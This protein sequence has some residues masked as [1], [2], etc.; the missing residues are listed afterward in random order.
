MFVHSVQDKHTRKF[1]ILVNDIYDYFWSIGQKIGIN[2]AGLS[3]FVD[4]T[5]TNIGHFIF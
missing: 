5:I 4:W 2:N 3:N 1:D